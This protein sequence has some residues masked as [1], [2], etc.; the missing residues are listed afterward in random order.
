LAEIF[1]PK[2]SGKAP[3]FKLI[4]LL[5]ELGFHLP[6]SKPQINQENIFFSSEK[7][8]DGKRDLM[9]IENAFVTQVSW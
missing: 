8:P 4:Y 7:K 6:K 2:V 1:E 3:Y 5:S 9:L